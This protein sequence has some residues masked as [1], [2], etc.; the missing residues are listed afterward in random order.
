MKAS[1]LAIA[2]A[3][4]LTGCNPFSNPVPAGTVTGLVLF[5][6]QP[7]AGK[8]VTMT[9]YRK[10]TTDANCRYTFTGLGAGQRVYVTYSSVFDRPSPAAAADPSLEEG[11]LPNEVLYWQTAAIMLDSGGKDVPAFD[12]AYNGLLYPDK[13]LSLIVSDTSPV[14][15]HWSTH[16]NAQHYRVKVSDKAE[17]A[18]SGAWS[19]D[20][21]GIFAQAVAP[22]TYYGQ[23]EIDG[24]DRGS[25]LTRKRIVSMGP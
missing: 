8:R 15:F 9:V 19:S 20:P 13:G 7:A 3:V 24:G 17:F 22:G 12:V 21:T 25:G 10:A 18:A 23:V 5:N 11:G 14:P 6:G 1:L 4:T 16:P 2:A